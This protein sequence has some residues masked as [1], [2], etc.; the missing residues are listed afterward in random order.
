MITDSIKYV[1]S[2]CEKVFSRKDNLQRHVVNTHLEYQNQNIPKNEKAS[3]LRNDVSTRVNPNTKSAEK[4]NEYSNADLQNPSVSAVRTESV[5]KSVSRTQNIVDFCSK[6]EENSSNCVSVIK[7]IDEVN[8][9]DFDGFSGS[10]RNDDARARSSVD[11]AVSHY[12]DEQSTEFENG[13]CSRERWDH[14]QND[15]DEPLEQTR[16]DVDVRPTSPQYL[17]LNNATTDSRDLFLRS[18]NV[19]C[20][21]AGTVHCEVRSNVISH[22]S[23][24]HVDEELF[25]DVSTQQY[26]NVLSA[27]SHCLLPKKVITAS[28]KECSFTACEDLKAEGDMRELYFHSSNIERRYH[29]NYN[30]LDLSLKSQE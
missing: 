17:Y 28:Y 19:D 11:M 22:T 13:V 20:V 29:E 21:Y 5:I 25:E 9:C 6:P 24:I 10:S 8:S 27:K 7:R 26:S 16:F 23:N 2:I 15:F 30:L 1:C 18:E 14:C 4:A 3:K 12:I